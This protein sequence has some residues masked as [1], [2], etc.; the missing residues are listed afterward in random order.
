M[1]PTVKEL[2]E[3]LAA[4]LAPLKPDM[5][6]HAYMLANPTPPTIHLYPSG[7][8]YDQA[9]QRGYDHWEFT[10]EAF[11]PLSADIGVQIKLDEL[12]DPAGP[13]SVKALLR[14]DP[15]LGGVA[16]DTHVISS[17]GYRTHILEGRPPALAVDWT[18]EVYATGL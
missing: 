17:E 15:T 14:S 8:S 11:L 7:V 10:V 6:V 2:R 1:A 12:L 4:N 5:Q 13:R 3:G 9:M 16:S 18:V